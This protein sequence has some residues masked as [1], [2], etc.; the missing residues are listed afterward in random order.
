M[1]HLIISIQTYRFHRC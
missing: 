1:K